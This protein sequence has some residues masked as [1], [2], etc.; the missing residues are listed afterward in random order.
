MKL[1]RKQRLSSRAGLTMIEVVVSSVILSGLAFVLMAANVPLSKTSS[2]MGL[3]FDMDRSA[4]RFLTDLRREVRQSGYNY[5]TSNISTISVGDVLVLG[6]NGDLSYRRRLSFGNN[7]GTNWTPVRTLELQT[8]TL[9]SFNGGAPRYHVRRTD[10]NSV[11]LD[12]VK[13]LEFTLVVG[14]DAINICAVDVELTLARANPNWRGDVAVA[15]ALVER[16][17]NET[18]EFLNKPK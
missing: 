6:T 7:L 5:I 18:I 13:S 17:Y 16:Q 2:E 9:G 14:Q 4:A 10:I 11:I 3:A 8:S 12:H 1:V 15:K